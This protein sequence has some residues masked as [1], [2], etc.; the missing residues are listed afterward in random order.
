MES[1]YLFIILAFA[2]LLVLPFILGW[3]YSAPVY[4]GPPSDHFDG[5]KFQNPGH[6]QAK[7]LKEL[8]KWA[9][10]RDRGKW[11]EIKTASFGD[12]PPSRVG[13][14][15]A[16]ITF[17]NHSTFL[18]QVSGLNIL[19]DPIW[20][21]RASPVPFI[22]P[23]R[24]RPPGIFIEDLP[25]I[26]I[27][28]LSH[29]HYDHLDIRT[30]KALNRKFNPLVV[31]PLGVGKYLKRHGI[32]RVVEMDWW[33]SAVLAGNMKVTCTP[34]QHFS[35]RG[36]YDRD[37]TLWAGFALSTPGGSIYFAGDSGYGSFFREIGE[38]IGPVRLALLPI[39]A[40]KPSWFM[41]PIHTS[42]E[43][44]VLVH[45]D[46]GSRLSIGTHFG[47]FPLADDGMDDPVRELGIALEKFRISPVRFVALKEGEA[48]LF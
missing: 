5:K 35:G 31:C 20:S 43:D 30:L 21:R 14:D 6:V 44:A 33:D 36:F 7:S 8:I 38:R 25:G 34:A 1:R 46:L 47:T 39:G 32:G 4:E 18:I 13:N 11:I 37:K 41:S 3:I 23:K 2:A 10:N 24:M 17:V 22:G 40:Y 26:D 27:I 42:P 15:S 16:R 12:A 45:L 9:R 28:L 48:M 29:N 19:T